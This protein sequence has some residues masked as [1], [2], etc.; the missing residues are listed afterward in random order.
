MNGHVEATYSTATA[1]WSRL[2][3]VQDPYI[4]L[5]GL[6]PA[7][8]YAQQALEGLKAFRAPGEA[9]AITLFRPDR[10]ARRLQHSAE[11]LSMPTV[12]TAM[13]VD[14]CRAAVACNAGFVPPSGPGGGGASGPGG[15]GDGASG[16][17][18][19]YVRPQLYGSGAVLPPSGPDEFRFCVYVI[20]SPAGV[21]DGTQ[22]V[23]ALILDDFDRAAPRGTGHAKVGGNYA[24]VLRW[25]TRARAG[26]F[27][28]TLHLDSARH[29]HVDEF[30]TC[31]F[32]GVR[33]DDDGVTLLVPDSP[34]V[35]DSVTSDSV[36][37]IARSFGWR[38]ERR[39][40]PYTELPTLSEVLGAGT[41]VA[42]TPIRS[43]TRL[44]RHSDGIG[45]L[46]AGPRVRADAESET[47]TYLLDEQQA[48]GPVY[49][50][51]RERLQ[52]IQL[53]IV[54]DEFGW[55]LEVRAEDKEITK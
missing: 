2:R 55:C 51:L 16:G 1:E 50:R 6:S 19:L 35:I 54:K 20:P 4:R 38:V 39:A 52:G 45:A 40:V 31:A 53:G 48:G 8:N 30:S 26:G 41:G 47:I 34:C 36:Q 25:A 5:H 29:E 11:V 43:I 18:S 32:L 12:P 17:G 42:L 23:R 24:P 3:F 14:A 15:A 10:N 21:H 33:A 7:L 27:G 37:H 49:R 22:P 46:P 28:I 44:L 13:F 9:G